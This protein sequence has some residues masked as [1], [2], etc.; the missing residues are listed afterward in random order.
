MVATPAQPIVMR[1]DWHVG[2]TRRIFSCL[3]CVYGESSREGLWIWL[4]L[5]SVTDALLAFTISTHQLCYRLRTLVFRWLGCGHTG[6]AA[7]E[8][9]GA[10][11]CLDTRWHSRLRRTEQ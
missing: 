8:A 2:N 3:N 7:D 5:L 4:C 9:L 11:T 10:K 1:T 6:V